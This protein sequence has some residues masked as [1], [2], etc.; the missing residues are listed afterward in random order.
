[1]WWHVT[2][3]APILSITNGVHIPT[4]QAK[5]VRE[6]LHSKSDLSTALGQ[7]KDRLLAE[8][9]QENGVKLQADKLLVGFARRAA[10]YKRADLLFRR[11][12]EVE[13]LLDSGS[14]QVVFSGK[15]HP[16]DKWGK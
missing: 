4:W 12:D 9:Q 16:Q 14:L 10:A 2:G 6:V 15:A 5:E 7:L 8:I 1:M 13:P 3:A 11:L